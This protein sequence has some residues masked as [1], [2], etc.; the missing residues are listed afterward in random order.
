MLQGGADPNFAPPEADDPLGAAVRAA[1]PL[2]PTQAGLDAALDAAVR[3]GHTDV[4][5]S[6]LR[7]RAK[8]RARHFVVAAHAGSSQMIRLLSGLPAAHAHEEE[9]DLL[10]HQQTQPVPA[11]QR[12]P[13][14]SAASGQANAGRWHERYTRAVSV[15]CARAY[16][17]SGAHAAQTCMSAWHSAVAAARHDSRA[18]IRAA[19]ML[20][21]QRQRRVHDT[22]TTWARAVLKSR[23]TPRSDSRVAASDCQQRLTSMGSQLEQAIA[24]LESSKQAW[25]EGKSSLS[26]QLQECRERISTLEDENARLRVSAGRDLQADGH[27]DVGAM[28]ALAR[29]ALGHV[30]VLRGQL[31]A[32]R[33]QTPDATRVFVQPRDANLI[34][35]VQKMQRSLTTSHEQVMCLHGLAA[36]RT[37]TGCDAGLFAAKVLSQ[38]RRIDGMV[39][40]VQLICAAQRQMTAAYR[41]ALQIKTTK[42]TKL[43][44]TCLTTAQNSERMSARLQELHRAIGSLDM[45]HRRKLDKLSDGHQ[46]RYA[47]VR[48]HVDAQCE[49]LRLS[50]EMICARESSAHVVVPPML[51]QQQH[52]QIV[53]P[54]TRNKRVR[55]EELGDLA[56]ELDT[57]LQQLL[58]ESVRAGTDERLDELGDALALLAGK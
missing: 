36:R 43:E 24:Q 13:L 10:G 25:C 26:R 15:V 30:G 35:L 19:G 7:A 9:S 49:R 48:R 50:T 2:P 47:G 8:V 16:R 4:A 5:A 40:Q 54:A 14:G 33:R 53:L 6:L 28:R 22:F 57:Q 3:A 12:L 39:D 32:A 11:P 38:R 1:A 20:V 44:Q 27:V 37:S 34:A 55:Y 21:R 23:V 29:Q 41:Q 42:I 17:A 45:L 31:R 52:Q 56:T 58:A 51:W 46:V 18:V